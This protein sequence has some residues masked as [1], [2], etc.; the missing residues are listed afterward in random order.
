MKL[1]DFEKPIWSTIQGEG[2]L[3]GMPSV[4]IRLYG[5]DFSCAWCDTKGSWKPGSTSV[6]VEIEGILERAR[7]FR[8]THAVIT[9]GNPLLQAADLAELIVGLQADWVDRENGDDWRA[10]MHV[11]VETQGSIFDEAVA[12][13]VDLISLSPK[14]HQWVDDP[15]RQFLSSALGRRKQAQVKIVCATADEVNVALSHMTSLFASA[16]KAFPEPGY[17]EERLHFILQP[18]SSGGRRGVEVV[19]SQLEQ[20]LRE[21]EAGY[22]YPVVRLIPQCHKSSLYVL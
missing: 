4:F 1:V 21:S 10:G 15:L 14:L 7:S 22:Q 16:K 11:T 5:C 9:G 8:L 20:W 17:V 12:R 6:P 13:H 3:V 19:R 18:E 2:T